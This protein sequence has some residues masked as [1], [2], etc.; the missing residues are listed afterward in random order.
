MPS[1][2]SFVAAQRGIIYLSLEKTE[3]IDYATD[4][5]IQTHKN[6]KKIYFYSTQ[7]WNILDTATNLVFLLKFGVVQCCCHAYYYSSVLAVF[8]SCFFLLPDLHRY[9][10]CVMP[11]VSLV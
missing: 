8:H 3:C 11:D 4:A 2:R 7:G 6:Y 1:C 10:I 5:S 9:Q